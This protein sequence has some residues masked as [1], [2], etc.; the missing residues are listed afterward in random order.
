MAKGLLNSSNGE[1][2]ESFLCIIL[3]LDGNGDLIWQVSSL[4]ELWDNMDRR[5]TAKLKHLAKLIV[6]QLEVIRC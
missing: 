5:F 4:Q 2:L 1:L 6:L 3:N